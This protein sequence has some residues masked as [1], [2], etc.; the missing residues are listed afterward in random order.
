MECRFSWLPGLL[1][2]AQGEVGDEG[3]W[4]SSDLEGAPRGAARWSIGSIHKRR[5]SRKARLDYGILRDS[6]HQLYG[7]SMDGLWHCLLQ[8]AV[9]FN[10]L[11]TKTRKLPDSCWSLASPG[12]TG[13]IIPGRRTCE[14]THQFRCRCHV[15]DAVIWLHPRR[16]TYPHPPE[17][18]APGHWQLI[19]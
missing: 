8:N 19:T 14:T 11:Q 9:L 12:D 2:G 3:Q 16:S 4:P 1:E 18:G 7:W 17:C 5:R 15:R 6:I 10:Q 13:I